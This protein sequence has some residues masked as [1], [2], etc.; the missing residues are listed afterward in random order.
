M[1][2]VCCV[3]IAYPLSSQKFIELGNDSAIIFDVDG[4]LCDTTEIHFEAYN[5]TLDAMALPNLKWESYID[6]CVRNGKKITDVVETLCGEFDGDEFCRRKD[7]F[8]AGLVQRLEIRP[9]A[10]DTLGSL[11]KAGVPVAFV[12]A[13]RRASLRLVL[14][15]FPNTLVPDT[16]I[17][18]EDVVLGKPNPMPY[19][20]ALELLGCVA[21]KSIAFEDAPSG[22]ASAKAAG[23]TCIALMN[24]DFPPSDQLSADGV[25]SSFADFTIR[26]G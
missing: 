5:R 14:S 26:A 13:A 25:I 16:T 11:K 18:H 24:S 21:S 12:T 6:N 22:I 10:L 15:Q 3:Q 19:D 8:F 9:A 17:C 7:A 23:L 1:C 20:M 2:I 4:T